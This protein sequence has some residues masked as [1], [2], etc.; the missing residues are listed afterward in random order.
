MAPPADHG[1]RKVYRL[2]GPD[3]HRY[4][5]TTPGTLGGNARAK[6]YGRLD[7]GSALAAIRDH[8]EAYTQHRVFFAD[9]EAAVAAGYRPCGN[10]MRDRFVAWREKQARVLSA[11]NDVSWRDESH[12]DRPV[13]STAA[14]D[15]A[16]EIA[17]ELGLGEKTGVWQLPLRDGEVLRLLFDPPGTITDA[18]KSDLR[19]AL[20]DAF[21]GLDVTLAAAEPITGMKARPAALVASFSIPK[22]SSV[23]LDAF[24]LL[25]VSHRE[26]SYTTLVARAFAHDAGFRAAL[27]PALGV[28]AKAAAEAD[29]MCR[30]RVGVTGGDDEKSVPDLV[31]FS[32]QARQIVIVEAKIHAGE[33]DR[34][35]MRYAVPQARAKLCQRLGLDA[36][37][38]NQ[39][40]FFLTLAGTPPRSSW[41]RPLRWTVVAE[42]AAASTH[43]DTVGLLLREL[44]AR[45]REHDAWPAPEPTTPVLRYLHRRPGLVTESVVFHRLLDA[46]RMQDEG[47]VT[48]HGHTANPGCGYIPLFKWSKPSWERR[49]SGGDPGMSV[50]FELQWNTATDGLAFYLHCETNPY[51]SKNDFQAKHGDAALKEHAAVQDELFVEL[52]RRGEALEAAGW[53]FRRGY[54]MLAGHKFPRFI[55]VEDFRARVRDLIRVMAAVVDGW[56]QRRAAT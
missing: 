8:G 54:N 24:D 3:G 45:I 28:P 32:R 48:S 40:G 50:H 22:A 19:D 21:D 37:E 34:G 38:S 13:E 1:A 16:H 43:P 39:R 36:P 56:A 14:T 53:T 5:S 4:E 35:T 55:R 42:A 15:A 44:A 26:D 41:F 20:S 10:C 27:L 33:G 49:R 6:I 30:L 18:L 31:F 2:L 23:S 25:G 52:E 46:A 7:C 17:K 11:A 9:E 47:F 29:W 12:V 51:L